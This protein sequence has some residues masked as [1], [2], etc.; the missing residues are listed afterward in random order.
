[1]TTTRLLAASACLLLAAS[2]SACSDESEKPRA[3]TASSAAPATS[4]PPRPPDAES[5]IRAWLDALLKM[6]N[7]G[8]TE[9]FL[10]LSTKDCEYCTKFATR[11]RN[12]YAAGGTAKIE[13]TELKNISPLRGDSKTEY[14]V[15]FV[16]GPGIVHTTADA[17]P[18]KFRGGRQTFIVT[19]RN[20]GGSWLVQENVDSSPR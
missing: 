4:E 7:T 3:T 17:E 13:P 5:A 12:V 2:L 9:P 1:M 20:E 14:V 10:A 11:V 6:Q 8:D 16:S 19:V 15:Q 18:E